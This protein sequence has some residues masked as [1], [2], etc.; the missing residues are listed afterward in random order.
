MIFDNHV[1]SVFFYLMPVFILYFTTIFTC[2]IYGSY[3]PEIKYNYIYY[4]YLFIYYIVR[5]SMFTSPKMIHFYP[6]YFR[7]A[8]GFFLQVLNFGLS[9]SWQY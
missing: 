6:L 3:R 1:T 9:I 4:L 7:S 5:M 8:Q 2:S